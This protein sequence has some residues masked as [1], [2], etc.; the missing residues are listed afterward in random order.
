MA[1]ISYEKW[2]S[3]G[4]Y[5]LGPIYQSLGR[6]ASF[7]CCTLARAGNI[8]SASLSVS[9]LV[10]VFLFQL[11]RSAVV[12]Y[13]S[14]RYVCACD[15]FAWSHWAS[16]TTFVLRGLCLSGSPSFWFGPSDRK[17]NTRSLHSP[18][19]FRIL[20]L[21]VVANWRR[22]PRLILNTLLDCC[23]TSYWSIRW[24]SARVSKVLSAAFVVCA[25]PHL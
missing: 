8:V 9:R 7:A 13:I 19:D 3:L 15:F 17:R 2:L 1:C 14:V 12:T 4:R 5:N 18:I 11:A 24:T 25:L 16:L 22:R 20:C 10:I 6:A 21:I 23:H